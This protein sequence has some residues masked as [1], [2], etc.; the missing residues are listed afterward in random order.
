MQHFTLAIINAHFYF[1]SLIRFW[2]IKHKRDSHSKLYLEGLPLFQNQCL[3]IKKSECHTLFISLLSLWLHM[4][5]SHDHWSHTGSARPEMSWSQSQLSV[6]PKAKLRPNIRSG[7]NTKAK[8]ASGPSWTY[9]CL[10]CL[11]SFFFFLQEE[12]ISFMIEQM[13]LF[14]SHTQKL[15]PHPRKTKKRMG[16]NIGLKL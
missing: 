15:A 16:E 5:Q 10:R 2:H 14:K 6:P 11:I 1:R 3:T 4:M 7:Q 8:V 9:S 12:C 13:F